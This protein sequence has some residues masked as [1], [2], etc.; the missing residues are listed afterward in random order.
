MLSPERIATINDLPLAEMELEVNKGRFSRFNEESRA[1]MASLIAE[2]HAER[3]Q[4]VETRTF[5]QADRTLQVTREGV[6]WGKWAA[7]IALLAVVVTVA[8]AKLG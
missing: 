4:A 8:L 3:L 2:R 7:G 1:L 6:R 5:D